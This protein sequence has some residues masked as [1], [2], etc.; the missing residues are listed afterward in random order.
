MCIIYVAYII[1]P[2]LTFTLKKKKSSISTF[3]EKEL[4]QHCLHFPAFP[5]S[6]LEFDEQ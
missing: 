4:I 1:K 2:V 5:P 6:I 3:A